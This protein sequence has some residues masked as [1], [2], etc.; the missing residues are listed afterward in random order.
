MYVID[1]PKK[2]KDGWNVNIKSK[3]IIT[4]MELL[5]SLFKKKDGYD[6]PFNPHPTK[7]RNIIDHDTEYT[8]IFLGKPFDLT[9]EFISTKIG[10]K[11][12][13][14]FSDYISIWAINLG[15][16]ELL[17][18]CLSVGGTNLKWTE[19]CSFLEKTILYKIEEDTISEELVDYLIIEVG[20]DKFKKFIH[21][22]VGSI[23]FNS[24]VN[25]IWQYNIIKK[26][27]PEDDKEAWYEFTR[28]LFSNLQY[29]KNI[30]NLMV[31]EGRIQ[32]QEIFEFIC[33]FSVSGDSMRDLLSE[34]LPEI[35][36]SRENLYFL[37]KIVRK[38]DE[39]FI[40]LC[41]E[42]SLY[43]KD[44]IKLIIELEVADYCYGKND[45]RH[46]FINL[47]SGNKKFT[48]FERM[49]YWFRFYKC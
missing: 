21:R 1:D 35:K 14:M 28:R 7:I 11:Q 39:M 23:R 12:F 20:A 2:F 22:L 3:E 44:D 31:E 46:L 37:L 5:S 47:I 40:N 49:M 10:E 32:K 19:E 41:R 34:I 27:Y 8:N 43:T 42:N 9:W 13:I 48:M 17:K 30:I 33:N 25:P 36:A 24:P 18:K 29:C 4:S 26:Y 15:D 38:F 6:L 16:L 45:K